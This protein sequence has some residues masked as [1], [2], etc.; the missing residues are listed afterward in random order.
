[1]D[2]KALIQEALKEI[3]REEVREALTSSSDSSPSTTE[4]E[5]REEE[6]EGLEG[7]ASSG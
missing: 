7:K 2:I 1:M 3:I 6:V 5:V 4:V